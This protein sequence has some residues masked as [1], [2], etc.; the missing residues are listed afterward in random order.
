VEQ[1]IATAQD[2]DKA[3][4]D[5]FGRRLAFAGPF[6]IAELIGW[7]LELRIQKYLFP[8]LDASADPSPLV[9][10]KVGRGEL[11]VKTGKG[12]Y[13]WTPESADAW[14]KAMAEA[15]AARLRVDRFRPE[16]G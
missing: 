10:E 4:R 3:V 6:E 11:G 12:F 9:V 5:G 7:D 16:A 13:D 1:G 8:H 14:R 15:L 2:V